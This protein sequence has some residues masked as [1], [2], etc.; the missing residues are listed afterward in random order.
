[1]Q[2][3]K[4]QAPARKGK[5]KTVSAIE[6]RANLNTKRDQKRSREKAIARGVAVGNKTGVNASLLAPCN[7]Y[8]QP[9]FA[10]RGYYVD[11]PFRCKD[12]AKDEV[13]TA[14]QQK[15]WY[16]VAKGYVYSSPTRCRACRR[17][18]RW[19]QTETQHHEVMADELRIL[20]A[21]RLDYSSSTLR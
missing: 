19:A 6:R 13:W 10:M 14:E 7:S 4:T 8:G 16:E 9:D 2:T 11:Q 18:E 21:N 15:W 3:Q 12:C 5:K 20:V 1:M 17:K